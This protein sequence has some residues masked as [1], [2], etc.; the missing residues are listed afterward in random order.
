VELDDQRVE[1]AFNLGWIQLAS[2]E[3]E[4]AVFWLR[5][6][7]QRQTDDPNARLVFSWALRACGRKDEADKQWRLAVA[8]HPAYEQSAEP[9]LGKRF[10]RL[11]LLERNVAVELET[12]SDDELSAAAIAQAERA[13]A[14]GDAEQALHELNRAVYLNPHSARAHLLL[15]RAAKARGQADL[16]VAELRMSLW[17]REDAA[18]RSELIEYLRAVGREAEAKRAET[19]GAA[20]SVNPDPASA[21]KKE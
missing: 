20:G 17:C 8:A 10:E 16:V 13:L 4:A 14:G 7:A 1:P 3:A 12:R 19:E 5:G 6:V 15:A 9:D 11:C 2:G 18:V 21:R